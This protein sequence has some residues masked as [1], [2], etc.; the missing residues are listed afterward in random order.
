MNVE[1]LVESE[2][3]WKIEVLEK[4]LPQCHFLHHNYHMTRPEIE[5]GPQW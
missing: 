2:L 1:Q 4:N 5:P 3:V